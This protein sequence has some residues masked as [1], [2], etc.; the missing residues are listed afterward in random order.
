MVRQGA[1]QRVL[2]KGLEERI[3]GGVKILDDGKGVV[4]HGLHA[5]LQIVVLRLEVR[6]VYFHSSIAESQRRTLLGWVQGQIDHW[7]PEP[8]DRRLQLTEHVELPCVGSEGSGSDSRHGMQKGLH[9]R[10]L[11]RLVVLGTLCGMQQ[12]FR[13]Q[14]V[15]QPL[16]L[17]PM[18][19]LRLDSP[20][21]DG[22]LTAA[23]VEAEY[24]ETGVRLK[25]SVS[26]SA[27]NYR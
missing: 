18:P 23:D 9:G 21:D 1:E 3:D 6:D 24:D 5:L 2:Q 4:Q 20:A 15:Q 8:H 12:V 19:A 26:R 13:R 25:S 16:R 22:M 7:E 27:I 10:I 14:R 11:Q 17:S